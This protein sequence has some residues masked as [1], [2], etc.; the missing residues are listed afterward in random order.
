[1]LWSSKKRSG[2]ALPALL[3]F[4]GLV[5]AAFT[6]ACAGTNTESQAEPQVAARQDST[7]VSAV[8]SREAYKRDPNEPIENVLARRFPGVDVSTGP[9]GALRIRIRGMESFQ[10]NTEPLIVIDDIPL[11]SGHRGRL[12]VNPY[13]I[14]SI[15]VLKHASE[16]ALYGVRGANGVIIIKTRQPDL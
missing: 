4:A 7:E 1:M 6:T 8:P 11:G 2:R 10:A 12:P 3:L 14:E 9:G 16:T 5:I 15:Q 13:D